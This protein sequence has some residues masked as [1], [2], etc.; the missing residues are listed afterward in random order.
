MLNRAYNIIP[1]AKPNV[2]LIN[3]GTNDATQNFAV[4]NAYNR[5]RD[6]LDYIFTSTPGVSIALS[7]LL[8][9][10]LSPGNV[11]SINHQYRQLVRDQASA[12]RHIVLAEM[13][14]GFITMADLVDTTH[15]NDTGFKKMASVWYRAIQSLGSKTWLSPPSN[16]VSFQDGAGGDTT[17]PKIYGSGNVDPRGRTQVLKAL[18][19]RIIDDGRYR[20]SAQAQGVVHQGWY[21]EPDDVWFAQLVNN[22]V[23]RSGEKDD[24]VFSQGEGVY[25]YRE[26]LGDQGFGEKMHI[27]SLEGVSCDREGVCWGDVVSFLV[28]VLLSFF[29][30]R[31]GK[32]AE[33]REM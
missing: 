13:H 33:R 9:N 12:G 11:A 14:D 5:M 8:P 26:N 19:L 7:T 30:P 6:M 22:G 15:P 20:H 27:V 21:V 17:C 2:V 29:Y 1:L 23:G 18:S 3:A 28:F 31:E 25:Y 10:T 4:G 32:E 16:A 24:W